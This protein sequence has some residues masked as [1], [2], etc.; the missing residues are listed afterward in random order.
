MWSTNFDVVN[1]FRCG[2]PILMWSTFTFDVVNKIARVTI[3]GSVL[4][5]RAAGGDGRA[6]NLNPLPRGTMEPE[7]QHE[8]LTPNPESFSVVAGSYLRLIDSCIP[9]SVLGRRADGGDGRAP[10]PNP[11]VE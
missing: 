1:Q 5:R 11:R 7:P 2:Q 8:T 10:T 6:R 9:G 4:D 3:P